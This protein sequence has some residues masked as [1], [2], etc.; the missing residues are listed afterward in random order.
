[1]L[2]NPQGGAALDER[3]VKAIADLT[4]SPAGVLLV[5]DA[6]GLGIGASWNWDRATLP[7]ASDTALGE[8]L[9]ATGRIIELD[10]VRRSEDHLDA[11]TVPQWML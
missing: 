9:Q 8:H 2:G 10:A 7:I 11:A 6:G 1:T 3:I 4:E 5:P